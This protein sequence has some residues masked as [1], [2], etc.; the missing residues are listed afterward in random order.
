MGHI[1]AGAAVGDQRQPADAAAAGELQ[2]PADAAAAAGDQQQPADAAAAAGNQQQPA[3]AAVTADILNARAIINIF[4]RQ[5]QPA[6]DA[7]GPADTADRL[8][9][10]PGVA[11]VAGGQ[12]PGVAVVAGGQ[13]PGMLDDPAIMADIQGAGVAAAAAARE[14]DHRDQED[15][16]AELGEALGVHIE[17]P[18]EYRGAQGVHI[19]DILRSNIHSNSCINPHL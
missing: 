15:F 9:D 10:L 12:L 4:I 6:A 14:P 3:D 5:P 17:V 18:D 11:A 2:Q 7:L 8:G 16:L 1:N 13:L 19:Y